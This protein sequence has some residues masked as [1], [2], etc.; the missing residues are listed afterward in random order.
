[1]SKLVKKLILVS[2]VFVSLVVLPFQSNTAFVSCCKQCWSQMQQCLS[3][4]AGDPDCVSNCY[5]A[6]NVCGE[7]CLE[8][9]QEQCPIINQ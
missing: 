2:L 9:H 7:A 5:D 4:C 1:M 8:Q 6:H 3:T